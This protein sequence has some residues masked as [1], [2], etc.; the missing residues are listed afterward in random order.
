M[1]ATSKN[2]ERTVNL[3]DSMTEEIQEDVKACAFVNIQDLGREF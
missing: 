1:N 3:G 2:Q